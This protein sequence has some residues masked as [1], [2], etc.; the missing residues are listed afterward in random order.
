MHVT[1][2]GYINIVVVFLLG[3]AYSFVELLNF[4]STARSFLKSWWGTMYIF[5]NGF[6]GVI[7]LILT[8]K[9][10]INEHFLGL[11]I[12]V[13]GTSALALLRVIIVPIKHASTGNNIMPMIDIILNHVKIAYDRERSKI[14][15]N[16]IKKIMNGVDYQKAAESLPVLCSNLLRT[17][18]EEEGKKMNEEIQKLLTL[19]EGGK[20]IKALNLGI[21]LAKYIGIEL[22]RSTV[23]ATREFISRTEGQESHEGFGTNDGK[24]LNTLIEKFS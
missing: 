2:I 17:I 13:A 21:I 18:S 14:D 10:E 16:D 20:E 11:K 9:N 4:F 1:L 5:L 6:L 8:F 7:A 3:T 24:D 12:L 22:L 15:L 19:D 23:N